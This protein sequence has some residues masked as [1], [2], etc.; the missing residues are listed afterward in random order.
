VPGKRTRRQAAAAEFKA[1][2]GIALEPVAAEK[3]PPSV[4]QT[5]RAFGQGFLDALKGYRMSAAALVPEDQCRDALVRTVFD[6]VE[7]ERL[8]AARVDRE[9]RAKAVEQ[10]KREPPLPLVPVPTAQER[11]A[12]QMDAS[13][14][15][16]L[17]SRL[18]ALEQLVAVFA[19]KRAARKKARR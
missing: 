9:L 3:V 2:T 1:L 15:T 4:R 12:A 7:L 8:D 6:L 10:A 13:A 14:L 17:R 11:L 5:T 16:E 19:P 18:I